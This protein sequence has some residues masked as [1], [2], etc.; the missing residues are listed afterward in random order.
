LSSL[1]LA[2]NGWSPHEASSPPPDLPCSL[3]SLK[4]AAASPDKY[5]LEKSCKAGRDNEP[6]QGKP[7][8]RAGRKATGLRLRVWDRVA[9]PPGST[10][11]LP[12]RWALYSLLLG[13]AVML[14]LSALEFIST[15]PHASRRVRH[16]A[17]D[18]SPLALP[19]YQ[20]RIGC[21]GLHVQT[22]LA[23]QRGVAPLLLALSSIHERRIL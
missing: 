20:S 8:E 1:A 2:P 10:A 22:A 15:E 13:G 5:C 17:T 12:C 9:G 6:D 7:L 18:P 16:Q 23:M 11:P 19:Q 14:R 4:S 21:K 3:F